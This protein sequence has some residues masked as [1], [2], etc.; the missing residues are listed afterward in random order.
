MTKLIKR[1]SAPILSLIFLLSMSSAGMAET[2]V[3]AEVQAIFNSLLFLICGFLGMVMAA[4]FAMLE[5]GM[6]TS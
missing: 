6:V 5:S 2:T 3:S 4:G 1:I